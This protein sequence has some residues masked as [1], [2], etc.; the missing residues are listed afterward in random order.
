MMKKHESTLWI[1]VGLCL[2]MCGQARATECDAPSS[3]WLMC[4]D[5]EGG[6]AGWA[7]WFSASPFVECN[8]CPD[9]VPDPGRIALSESEAHT[10]TWS[11][12]MPG[13]ASA[14]YRGASLTYRT[15]EGQKQPGCTLTGYDQ[16][17]YRAWVKLAPEHAYVHHFMS[18]AGTR[19]NGYWESDGNA[20]CRPNGYRAA[21]TTL[22]FNQNHELFFYTYH[23][24]MNC[25]SGGYCSGQY[26]QD[27][28][29]G[30]ATKDMPCE[31]G[32]ECCWGNHFST[33]PQLVLPRGQWVCLEMMQKIN[34]PGQADGE[35]AYWMDG[36]LGHHQMGMHWRDV[37]ELQLNKV[38]VQHYIANGDTDQENP[39]WWD[40]IVVSTAPIGCDQSPVANPDGGSPAPES[41]GG[42]EGTG[43]NGGGNGNGDAGNGWTP[44][45]G[46][47]DGAGADSEDEDGDSDPENAAATGC[48]CQKTR[49]DP[50]DLAGAG[51]FALIIGFSSANRKRRRKKA[52]TP[53][54][55]RAQ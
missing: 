5:F 3:D 24:D 10:G 37:A 30:C 15:C 11:L 2:F 19:P 26:A 36:E 45:N 28:C 34:T 49:P 42:G 18:I 54:P 53:Q 12:H 8:G 16:L 52:P 6:A 50:A 9:G 35:M 25:D 39:I 40:D 31:N 21:G 20:G 17:Y 51:I 1:C 46:G 14:N 47:Q 23:P 27:I 22:D 43:E 4:E 7:D 48:G 33:Q 44:G 38:W 41:D 29:D 32:N 55:R 13:A